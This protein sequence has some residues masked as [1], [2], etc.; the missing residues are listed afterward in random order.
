VVSSDLVG[1]R[2]RSRRGLNVAA[3]MLV[4]AA[5]ALQLSAQIQYRL[6]SQQAVE[7]RLRAFAGNDFEREERLKKMFEESGCK[8]EELSEQSVKSK[9][10]A[11]LI[12]VLPGTSDEE[13]VVG[14]HFDHV[15]AGDGVVDNWSGASLLPSLL[16]SLRQE[17]RRYTF[18]FIG[19]MGEE[20]EMMGSEFYT[21]H[22][23]KEQRARIRAMIN[24]D[25]LGLGPTEVWVSHSDE[26]LL[27]VLDAVA[28]A[29]KLPLRGVNV[30]KVGT[31]DSESFARYKIPRITIHTLT[32]ETLSILHSSKDRL[33]KIRMGD[34]YE[35]YRLIA[36]YL[37]ALDKLLDPKTAPPA[38]NSGGTTAKDPAP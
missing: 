32:Q 37:I 27:R 33:D 6:L 18:V 30:D 15:N 4:V 20:R 1:K 31:T 35:S 25:T 16:F 3:A 10:P 24:I 9:Q 21:G 28:N 14:A 22:L 11:N 13:I 17:P 7:A 34:Y 23:T 29:L 8:P 26:T 19:F 2:D 12:C 36:G 38:P 5:T